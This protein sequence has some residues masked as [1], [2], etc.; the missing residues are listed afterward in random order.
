M[1]GESKEKNIG[2]VRAFGRMRRK[3]GK[4]REEKL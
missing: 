4:W 3:K 2:K 1:K